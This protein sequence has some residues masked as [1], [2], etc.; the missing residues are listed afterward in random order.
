MLDIVRKRQVATRKDHECFACIKTIKK[1]EEA[2]YVTGKQDNQHIRVYLHPK[3]NIKTGKN[4]ADAIYYKC[5]NKMTIPK[6]MV[7][8]TNKKS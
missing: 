7:Q 1:G 3:C 8:E 5:A 4:L 2:I 6:W